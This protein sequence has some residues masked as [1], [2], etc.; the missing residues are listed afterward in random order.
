MDW[1]RVPA[2]FCGSNTI[3][4]YTS[5]VNPM[6]Q[7]ERPAAPT[8]IGGQC[9]ALK[10]GFTSAL[11][12]IALREFEFSRFVFGWVTDLAVESSCCCM[13]DSSRSPLPEVSASSLTVGFGGRAGAFGIDRSRPGEGEAVSQPAR[14]RLHLRRATQHPRSVCRR[15]FWRQKRHPIRTRGQK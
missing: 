12:S 7:H 11:G 10:G 6:S 4:H 8:R 13:G 14:S 5:P 2:R 9:A 1:G 3:P 15:R